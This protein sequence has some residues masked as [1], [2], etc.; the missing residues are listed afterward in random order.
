V[1]D[2]RRIE[3]NLKSGQE[4]ALAVLQQRGGQYRSGFVPLTIP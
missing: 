4:I 3:R 1:D 2:F